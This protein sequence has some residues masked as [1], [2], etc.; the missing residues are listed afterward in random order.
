FVGKS[1]KEN[2]MVRTLIVGAGKGGSMLVKQMLDTPTMGMNPI[3][4][5]DDDPFKQKMEL[6]GG[7]KVEGK[8]EDIPQLIKK[9]DIKKIVI[10]IPSL[11]KS[12]LKEIHGLAVTDNVDVMIMPNIEDIMA[13][14]V[15]VNALKKVEVEDLLGRE[16]V[17]LDIEG[18]EEQVRDRVI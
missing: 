12:E 3:V 16:P 1:S 13:G 9:Y 8:R 11:S 7:V 5:V 2:K 10:A 6:N 15:E 14:R 4:A 17:E 18:I